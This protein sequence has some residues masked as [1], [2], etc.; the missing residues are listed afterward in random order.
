[1]R[2]HAQLWLESFD[3]LEGSVFTVV[4]TCIPGSVDRDFGPVEL[5][6][7]KTKDHS[8]MHVDA[9]SVLLHGPKAAEFCQGTYR[10]VHPQLEEV[11]LFLVPILAPGLS[12]EQVCYEA[13][14]SRLRE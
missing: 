11:D 10:L 12:Q 7:F 13:V 5:T 3:G 4:K 8:N 1:V 2:M 6:L 14:I 9:F